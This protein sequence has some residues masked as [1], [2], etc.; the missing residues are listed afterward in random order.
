[1]W[2]NLTLVT[3]ADVGAI[4]PQ[5]VASG[6]PWGAVV[7]P[8]ARAEA[9]RELKI[10]IES[11]FGK[12]VKNASDRILDLHR[13]DYVLSYIN[14][15]YADITAAAVDRL[16]DD[17]NLTTVFANAANR[18]YVGADY[19]FDG[20]SVLMKDALN[21]QARTLT[22]K[23]SGGAGFAA[24]SGATDGTTSAGA[25]FAQ[26]GRIAWSTIPSTWQRR[27]VGSTPTRST[28]SSSRSMSRSRR[29]RRRRRRSSP[30]VR[31]TG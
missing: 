19:Q 13:P 5:A 24:I 25:T 18:L 6:S 15:A 26:S 29:G 3:D 31:L 10:L 23:Y 9:K 1:M 30:C 2:S 28:G 22:A 4:E 11:A 21:A 27:L 20:V 16:E 12:T 14:S 17:V 7:W 8:S